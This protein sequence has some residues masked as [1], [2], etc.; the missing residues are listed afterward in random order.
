MDEELENLAR[1]YALTRDI[2]LGEQLGFGIHGIVYAAED[3]VK[4]G[5]FAPEISLSVTI[6][7]DANGL[8]VGLAAQA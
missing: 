4:P 5:F 3:N 7:A 8:E 1:Q 2:V 6:L